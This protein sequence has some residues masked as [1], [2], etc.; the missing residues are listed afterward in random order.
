M[1]K[2][3][4]DNKPNDPNAEPCENYEN[5]PFHGLQNPPTKVSAR[6]GSVYS[7]LSLFFCDSTT[8]I[9]VVTSIPGVVGLRLN[10]ALLSAHLLVV[11][12]VFVCFL[13]PFNNSCLSDLAKA[14]KLDSQQGE[15]PFPLPS[16]P[17]PAPTTFISSPNASF[18]FVSTDFNP[19]A[20][21]V[22]VNVFT[23]LA[24]LSSKIVFLLFPLRRE[25]L[26]AF[27]CFLF[28]CIHQ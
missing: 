23:L 9:A 8:L 1:E 6:C 15:N 7:L 26:Q 18:R 3:L 25:K 13:F 19:I 27:L 17:P 5:L 28:A 24:C 12:I 22:F 4:V 21:I 16:P 2:S 14:R 20:V 11:M 10:Q